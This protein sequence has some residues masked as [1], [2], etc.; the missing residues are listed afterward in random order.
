MTRWARAEADPLDGVLSCASFVNRDLALYNDWRGL[1]P[2]PAVGR[3]LPGWAVEATRGMAM[4]LAGLGCE[5][6]DVRTADGG[7]A[8]GDPRPLV[9]VLGVWRSG[10]E[11]VVEVRV[12]AWG[13]VFARVVAERAQG[14]AAEAMKGRWR[15][16]CWP[17][18]TA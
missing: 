18:C 13:E 2:A 11:V 15:C 8:T 1:R 7:L 12:D 9:G 17:W 4:R 10:G 6:V 14:L 16:E 5:V 3:A